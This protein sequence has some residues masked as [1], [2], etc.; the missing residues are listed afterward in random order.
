MFYPR[1]SQLI[2]LKSLL[3]IT[4]KRNDPFLYPAQ[5]LL[6]LR[7]IHHDSFSQVQLSNILHQVVLDHLSITFERVHHL[8]H[9]LVPPVRPQARLQLHYD[10]AL[11]VHLLCTYEFLP[12][13]TVLHQTVTMGTVHVLTLLA[14]PLAQ[15]AEEE[16]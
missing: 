16:L 13:N 1:N 8:P 11:E 7:D 3:I 2:F 15:R 9:L 10:Q 4:Q 14:C 6:H 12:E 5:L